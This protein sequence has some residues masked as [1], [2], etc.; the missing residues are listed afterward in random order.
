MRASV[1]DRQAKI[2]IIEKWKQSGLSQKEFL[3]AAAYSGSCVF[4]LA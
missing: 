4:L 1:S 3:S 2:D